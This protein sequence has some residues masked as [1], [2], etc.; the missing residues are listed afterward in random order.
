MARAQFYVVPLALV[1]LGSLPML[2][3]W[4]PE[5]STVPRAERPRVRAAPQGAHPLDPVLELAR[6]THEQALNRV[7]G[8]SCRLAKQERI[9]GVLQQPRLIDLRVREKSPYSIFLD[10]LA[11]ADVVSRRILYCEGKHDNKMLV[12]K[13]GRRLDFIVLR[14]EPHGYKAQ[15]ESLVPITQVG[16]HRLL[17]GMV[18]MLQQQVEADPSGA[19]TQVQWLETAELQGRPCLGVRIVHPQPSPDLG[20]HIA[21]VYLD[22]QLQLPVRIEARG[23]PESPGSTPPLLGEYLYTDL[24]LNS[25]LG[26]EHFDAVLVRGK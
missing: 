20:F 9:D 18:E 5:P 19:N 17:A 26:E 21:E 8:F 7:Q 2:K 13:G 1:A 22:R 25:R 10:F 23:W 3:R 6:R 15:A 14:L 16:F 12:R 11:P 4:L 24:E